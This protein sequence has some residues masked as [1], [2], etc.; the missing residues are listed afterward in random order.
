M[1]IQ[2]TAGHLYEMALIK[3]N[4]TAEVRR[5]MK[6][7]DQAVLIWMVGPCPFA[8]NL[9][10]NGPDIVQY[11]DQSD[12]FVEWEGGDWLHHPLDDGGVTGMLIFGERIA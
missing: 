7:N 5:Y 6:P 10:R 1:N 11:C 12:E 4:S 3:V 8:D 9:R 2:N